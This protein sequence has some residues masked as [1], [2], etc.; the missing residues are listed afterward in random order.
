MTKIMVVSNIKAKPFIREL[1][2]T[3]GGPVQQM[4]VSECYRHMQKYTPFQSGTLAHGPQNEVLEDGIL[5]NTPYAQYQYFGQL[6]VAPNGSSWARLG[7]TKHLAGKPLHYHGA[8][9]RG[10]HWDV[11]MWADDRQKILGE[12]AKKLGGKVV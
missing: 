12:I 10:S 2:L 4:L 11:R 7:E 1:G 8:P 6:M 3:P 9:M 5:Y